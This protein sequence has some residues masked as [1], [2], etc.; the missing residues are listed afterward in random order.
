MYSF[1]QLESISDDQLEKNLGRSPE[2]YLSKVFTMSSSPSQ[3]SELGI[4]FFKNPNQTN[5]LSDTGSE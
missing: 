5:A 4:E 1:T 2:S 3:D